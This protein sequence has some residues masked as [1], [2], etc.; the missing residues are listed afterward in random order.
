MH[1]VDYNMAQ[2]MM[3]NPA[4]PTC[5]LG[6]NFFVSD[7]NTVNVFTNIIRN[8]S[9]AIGNNGV[10]NCDF[11][12]ELKNGELSIFGGIRVSGYADMTT[13][14]LL[15]ILNNS[16]GDGS[17]GNGDVASVATQ[18][19]PPAKVVSPRAP[20]NRNRS[21]P[22]AKS[23]A[24][25]PAAKQATNKSAS[26]ASSAVALATENIRNTTMSI[27]INGQIV[28]TCDNGVAGEEH[29]N[30][31][32]IGGSDSRSNGLSS[33][34]DTFI[35]STMSAANMGG[36]DFMQA[37]VDDLPVVTT[38][39]APPILQHRIPYKTMS[40]TSA[41]TTSSSTNTESGNNTIAT[42][43]NNN[44]S[45]GGGA[46]CLQNVP[47]PVKRMNHA[48]FENHSAGGYGGI[49]D[50]SNSS[51]SDSD[52]DAEENGKCVVFFVFFPCTFCQRTHFFS[53]LIYVFFLAAW[54]I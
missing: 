30:G 17:N 53:L 26:L 11:E 41:T 2:E 1:A 15:Q 47:V 51:S 33:A 28:E 6:T 27:D 43:N 49:S 5:G 39:P 7:K 46:I 50:D 38:P 48:D 10:K 20:R 12:L 25:A 40:R 31:S 24:K 14:N 22:A 13:S 3:I 8:L 23:N 19:E 29:E 21:R 35:D 52:S 37:T 44:N 34:L 4:G 18:T 32:L 45:G 9:S 36:F 16:L 42:N 54:P